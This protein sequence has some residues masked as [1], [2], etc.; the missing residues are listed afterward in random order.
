M[1]I[2]DGA[3]ILAGSNTAAT[4]YMVDHTSQKLYAKC[5]PIVS[6][7]IQAAKVGQYWEPLAKTYNSVP[8]VD[9]VNPDLEDYTT[10]K[11]I[12]GL[13]KLMAEEEAKIRTNPAARVTTTLSKVFGKFW[14]HNN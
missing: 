9:D 13:F 6:K 3:K 11:C 14:S 1:D 12:R 8:F 7:S 4:E 2:E 5:K 10:K